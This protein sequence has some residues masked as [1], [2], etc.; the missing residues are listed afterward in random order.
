MFR[1]PAPAAFLA[2]LLVATVAALA[3]R[4]VDGA[5]KPPKIPTATPQPTVTVEPCSGCPAMFVEVVNVNASSQPSGP[6]K[7]LYAGCMVRIRDTVGNK[8]EG[9]LVEVVWSGAYSAPDSGLTVQ[10]ED[11]DTYARMTVQTSG[12]CRRGPQIFSCTVTRVSKDGMAYAP[13]LDVM[14][15]DSDDACP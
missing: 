3:P 11:G 2:G 1:S 6:A 14:T 5:G 12:D 7:G 8:V 10:Q 13:D 4:P 15:T 9:A